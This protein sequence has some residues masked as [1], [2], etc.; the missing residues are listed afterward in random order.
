MIRENVSL[1]E[2]NTFGLDVKARFLAEVNT[3]EQLRQLLSSPSL[4]SRKLVLGGGSNILFTGDYD[5]LVIVNRIA[6]INTIGEDSQSAQVEAGAGVNWHSFVTH[7]ISLNYPGLENL[8]LIPGCVGAAPHSKYRCLWRRD[9]I[10]VPSSRR[11]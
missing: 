1:R 4:P 6:H 2:L 11:N 5:G 3:T 10:Y 9:Q 8:S 7:V